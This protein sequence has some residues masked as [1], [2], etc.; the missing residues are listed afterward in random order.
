MINP[1]ILKGWTYD[2]VEKA[3]EDPT[4]R[5]FEGPYS[6]DDSAVWSEDE[7]HRT[8][9]QLFSLRARA[10]GYC[11]LLSQYYKKKGGLHEKLKTAIRSGPEDPSVLRASFTL[12]SY[13]DL[14]EP[15][16]QAQFASDE[17]K[18]FATFAA[19]CRAD[20]PVEIKQCKKCSTFFVYVQP[21]GV[22]GTGRPPKNCPDHIKVKKSQR[23]R[24]S[25]R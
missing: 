20:V 18:Y 21:K 1:D 3:N 8:Q 14:G 6:H 10:R 12:T 11:Q 15:L 4:S 9:A 19:L 7:G 24:R 2:L 22:V 23:K 17:A 25:R 13:T 5:K 16:L